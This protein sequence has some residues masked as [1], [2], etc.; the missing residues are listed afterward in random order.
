MRLTAPTLATLA[1]SLFV[2]TAAFAQ[3]PKPPPD[4]GYSPYDP[5]TP[6]TISPTCTLADRSG[7]SETD[8]RT[9]AEIVC[10]ELRARHADGTK[11]EIRFGTLGS[12]TLVTVASVGDGPKDERHTFI[13]GIDEITVAAPRLVDALVDN[14]PMG[15][16]RNV[17]N[18]LEAESRQNKYQ[19]G[20]MAFDGGIF[21]ATALGASS[22][23]SAGVA[24]GLVYRSGSVGFGAQGRLGGIGSSDKT[25]SVASLD[26][27]GRYYLSNSD[28][29]P[30][31]GAGFAISGFGLHGSSDD[32][33][34]S[35]S[36]FGAYGQ[37]GAELLRTHST[38]LSLA[39]RV[40]TP[41]YAMSE[42]VYDYTTRVD[43]TRSR[44][45]APVS[46]NVGFQFH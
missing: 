31:V 44:Y 32:Q 24:L 1:A 20:T 15:D 16:T 33:G 17:D 10:G 5:P 9:A 28:F 26:F 13:T 7:V 18:V 4:P 46:F 37:V 19:K 21:G 43:L 29:A 6:L 45:V 42:N 34:L 2:S 22:G 40:D 39:L 25:L 30:F 27:G 8:A 41:F 11:H 12:R 38:A 23:A 3:D 36:G 14:K 35:G